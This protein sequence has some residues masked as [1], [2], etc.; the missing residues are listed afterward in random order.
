MGSVKLHRHHPHI[1]MNPVFCEIASAIPHTTYSYQTDLSAKPQPLQSGF[2]GDSSGLAGYES[3][4]SRV[5]THARLV[6]EP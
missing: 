4:V 2:V 1:Y 6:G 5:P 3:N